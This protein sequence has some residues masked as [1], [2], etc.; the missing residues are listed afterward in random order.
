M[1]KENEEY[2]HNG[3]LAT[4]NNEILPFATTLMDLEIIILNQLEKD[5]HY[6]VSL[7]HGI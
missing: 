5:N 2:I 4:K 7:I 3:L 1:D 6:M